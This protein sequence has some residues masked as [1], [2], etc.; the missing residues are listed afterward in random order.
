MKELATERLVLRQF[1]A[2]DVDF[3]FD[4]YA[5]WEVQ[6]FIGRVP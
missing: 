6:R 1:D 2:S 3:V 4:L 5:R